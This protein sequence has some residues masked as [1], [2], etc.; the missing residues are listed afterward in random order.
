MGNTI[1]V[2]ETYGIDI[3]FDKSLMFWVIKLAYLN[4]PKIRTFVAT[5]INNH[6]Y[7]LLFLLLSI[8]FEFVNQR[9]NLI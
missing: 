9:N 3:I 7:D 6:Q 1:F 8:F 5:P 2:T 4:T